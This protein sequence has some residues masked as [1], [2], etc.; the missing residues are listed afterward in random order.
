MEN[1]KNKTI[2]VIGGGLAGTEAAYYL[3]KR[4]YKVKL[5]DIKPKAFTPAHHSKNYGELVCSNSLKSSDVY[6]N[7]CGLLKQEM[8]ELGSLI[9]SCADKTKVPAGNALAVDRELF[10]AEI[11]KKL[12]EMPNIE[13]ICEEKT[14]IDFSLPTII[15]TGPLT[16]DK[17]GEFIKKIT[18]AFYFFDAAAPIISGD[19]IEY[20]CTFSADRYGEEGGDYVNCPLDK[21]GYEKFYEALITAERAPLH[22]FEKDKVFEGCMPVEVMAARGKDTL[23]FGPLKPAGLTDPKTGRWP[24]ACLQLR[25]ENA[26]GTM[27]NMVGFQTNLLFGEQKKVFSMFPALK[28]AEFLRY[29]VMHKNTF[30]DSPKSLDKYFSLKTQPLCFFAGQLTGVEGYVESAASGLMAAI[31]MHCRLS[32]KAMPDWDCKTVSG[33]LACYISTENV[34]FQP[35]NANYGILS[36]L[37]I[38]VK[39]KAEKRV[40]FAEQALN[41]ITE[42]KNSLD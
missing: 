25:K 30:I 22:D 18:G 36:P 39:N 14:E 20:S 1:L 37:P 11:T 34:S 13:E 4:G 28:N 12:R 33:A 31:N 41:K 17:M 3:A 16:T 8:R 24:Y 6:G 10:A 15:A 27:Y 29:G 40:K 42:I 26:E 2:E 32:G 19:S 5:F 38:V 23:R 7:A 21:E 35:M 9:I